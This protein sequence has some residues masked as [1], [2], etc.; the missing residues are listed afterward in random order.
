MNEGLP[1]GIRDIHSDKIHLINHIGLIVNIAKHGK[2]TYRIV[3]FEVEP[4]SMEEN[5]KRLDVNRPWEDLW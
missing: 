1:L 2:D 5:E 3:G 4:L